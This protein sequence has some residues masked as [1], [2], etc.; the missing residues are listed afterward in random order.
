MNQTPLTITTE[1]YARLRLLLAAAAPS[2]R[3]AAL[4]QLRHELDRATLIDAKAVP[5]TVV[6]MGSR[7]EIEDLGTGEIEDYTLVFPER[8]QVEQRQLSVL[9][10]IGTALIGCSQGE[11]VRWTTPGG[12]RRFRIRR[13]VQADASV[14][15]RAGVAPFSLSRA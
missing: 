3:S 5:P 13:V 11:E 15:P 12:V 1:D 6:T 2:A 14:A 7:V 9:A 10:P 4:D 8:A